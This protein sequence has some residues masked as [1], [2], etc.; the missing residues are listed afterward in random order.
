MHL[1]MRITRRRLVATSSFAVLT[2]LSSQRL[3]S[4][5]E[6]ACVTLQSFEV[7]AGSH[8]H[9]VFPAADG[10]GVWFTAQRSGHL[11]LLTPTTGETELFDLG[12]NSAPHRVILG[13]DGAPWIT[14]GGRDEIQRV[15]PMTRD[16]VRYK[17]GIRKA[18]LNTAGFDREGRLWFTG[19]TGF[20]GVL[21]PESGAITS[22]E[23]PRGRGP[24]G[25]CSTPEG[26][27]WFVSLAGSYLGRLEFSDGAIIV[28]E[29]DPPTADSGTRRVWSDSSGN[30]WIAQWNAGQI[31]RFSPSDERWAE[32]K[33]PGEAPRA[34]AVYVDE[35]DIVW[36]TDFSS[37]AI[38]RFD[39]ET[40]T[41][42]GFELQRPDA[43]VRQ[44]A[45]RQGEVWGA[46]SGTDHLV[47]VRTVCA[48]P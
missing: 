3:V 14:D 27:V 18:N 17:T 20:L 11:G 23:S 22:I 21:D 9:D 13:P 2:R 40:G 35:N 15:D 45:G 28:T 1:G 32:W 8:P 16:I 34:Y 7:P 25:I 38:V 42:D 41:F 26:Q 4:A 33:L 36:L 44:L 47:V 5:N 46:E 30:L 48:G 37:N 39:R 6:A 31:A 24:Y 10:V 19:Q 29:F 12:R 43:A